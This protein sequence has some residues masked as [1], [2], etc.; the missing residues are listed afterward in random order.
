MLTIQTSQAIYHIDTAGNAH[1]RPLTGENFPGTTV[2]IRLFYDN[3]APEET[4]VLED[5]ASLF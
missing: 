4:D 5:E 1:P 3:L 2:S